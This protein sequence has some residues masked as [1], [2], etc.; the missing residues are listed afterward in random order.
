MRDPAATALPRRA[1]RRGDRSA[2]A[3]A[4]ALL[5]ALAVL[6][7]AA[8]TRADGGA[9]RARADRGSMTITLF[10]APTP[11]RAGD[12][13]VSVLVQDRASG[14]VLLDAAVTLGLEPPDGTA[15]GQIVPLDRQ[16]TRNQ[17]LQAATVHLTATGRHRLIAT[18]QRGAERVEVVAEVDVAAAPPALL[19]LWPYLA[20]PPVVVGIFLV[21]QLLRRRAAARREQVAR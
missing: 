15:T 13:D 7:H 10:T 19:A 12:A 20:L 5:L 2:A 9:V 21:Q 16:A 8:A 14:S 11:L 6:A 1:P 18:V 3:T 4:R 17:L